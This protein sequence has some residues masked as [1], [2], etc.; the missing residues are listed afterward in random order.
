MISRLE[1]ANSAQN[2]YRRTASDPR[3][4]DP[5]MREMLLD[6]MRTMYASVRAA[7]LPVSSQWES[8]PTQVGTMD[9]LTLLLQIQTMNEEAPLTMN[10]K[11]LAP[12]HSE[13]VTLD[14]AIGMLEATSTTVPESGAMDVDG[15][16][17]EQNKNRE[18]TEGDSRKDQSTSQQSIH[19]DAEGSTR[20][21]SS[22]QDISEVLL[23]DPL[24]AD[25]AICLQEFSEP[26][27]NSENAWVFENI[28]K[29]DNCVHY[30]H[31]NCLGMWIN[32]KKENSCPTCRT[33]VS[34]LILV[35]EP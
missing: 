26:K 21:T 8:I 13:T 5:H 25:C 23:G 27:K 28:V 19:H 15:I 20:P 4:S 30:F 17:K 32:I 10:R 6:E 7:R 29:V 31:R 35:P 24:H 22:L 16:I 2:L 18:K 3:L 14:Q 33:Q 1:L 11:H 9:N 12:M 34:P